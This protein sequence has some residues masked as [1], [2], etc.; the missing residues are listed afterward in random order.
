MSFDKIDQLHL[1]MSKSLQLAA[2]KYRVGYGNTFGHGHHQGFE[3]KIKRLFLMLFA[4]PA[5]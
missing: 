5:C 1:K 3:N 2:L 4:L